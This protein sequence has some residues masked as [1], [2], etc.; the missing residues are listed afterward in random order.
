MRCMQ[1]VLQCSE[2]NKVKNFALNRCLDFVP[3]SREIS[4]K[5]RRFYHL[6]NLVGGLKGSS[7]FVTHNKI[8]F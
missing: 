2:L 3:V 4:M 8:C 6:E 5:R 7:M 1:R